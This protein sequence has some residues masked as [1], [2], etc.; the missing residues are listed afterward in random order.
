MLELERTLFLQKVVDTQVELIASRPFDWIYKLPI[1][2]EYK[3]EYSGEKFNGFI[4][5]LPKSPRRKSSLFPR[6][7]TN[8][9]M[10]MIRVTVSPSGYRSY[11]SG[12]LFDNEK[13]VLFT[14]D[15]IKL[16]ELNET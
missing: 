12:F 9:F 7:K 13:V 2:S 10:L 6:R 15:E 14:K 11:T 16:S 1:L 8:S 5:F 4:Q 3:F